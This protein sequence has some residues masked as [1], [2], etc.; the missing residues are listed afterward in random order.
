MENN[1]KCEC[2]CRTGYMQVGDT[3]GTYTYN[4]NITT[5]NQQQ[6]VIKK[7]TRTE[8]KYDKD[9]KY[10]GKKIITEEHEE[11]VV[12]YYTYV[13]SAGTGTISDNNTTKL[14]S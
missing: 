9:G 7:I 12:P 13:Y 14:N 3:T 2:T 8:E 4:P 6:R 1:N 5:N 11:V 10:K